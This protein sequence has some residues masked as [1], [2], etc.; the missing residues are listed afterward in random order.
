[1]SSGS[2]LARIVGNRDGSDPDI[3]ALRELLRDYPYFAPA[4]VILAARLR[5]SGAD[6]EEIKKQTGIAAVYLPDPF[7]LEH[8]LDRI[9]SGLEDGATTLP[10]SFGE[11][12]IAKPQVEDAHDFEGPSLEAS[13][14][15][16]LASG[17]SGPPRETDAQKRDFQDQQSNQLGTEI[18]V[19]ETGNVPSGHSNAELPYSHEGASGES[20]P[21]GETP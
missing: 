12:K 4:Q 1:M 17:I 5:K 16:E 9:L 10:A 18:P 8:V 21:A 20:T 11:A 7:L 14:E 13:L 6:P 3:A 15:K 2:T 19:P